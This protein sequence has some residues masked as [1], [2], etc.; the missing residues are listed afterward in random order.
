MPVF[1]LLLLAA[2][3]GPDTLWDWRTPSNPRISPDGSKVVYQL[4]WADKMADTFHVNLWIASSDGKDNRPLTEG[5]H[6]DTAHVWSPD[7][8]SLAYISTRSGRP[9]VAVRYV[10]T[11]V[12]TTITNLDAAMSDLS[13]SLDSKWIAFFSRIKAKAAWSIKSTPPPS[14]AKWIE[15]PSVVSNLQWRAD[16]IGGQ[17]LLPESLHHLFVISADGVAPRQVTSGDFTH[18]G[19]AAWT[20]DGKAIILSAARYPAGA[21]LYPYDLHRVQ[22]DTGEMRPLLTR[23]GPESDAVVSPDGKWVAF[24][25]FED[26]AKS[27]HSSRL[28]V[29]GIDGQG[30]KMLAPSLDRN[31]HS[32]VWKADSTGLY[33][34]IESS[35]QSHLHI[36]SLSGSIEPLTSGNLRFSTAYGSS[37]AFRWSR[38]AQSRSLP[39]LRRIPRM[40]MHCAHRV[41]RSGLPTSIRTC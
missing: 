35:G 28:W 38:T 18:N 25:G 6:R 9:Q 29:V 26:K 40:S 2:T 19:P 30:L 24:L 17:G 15:G 13:W 20:P 39:P 33:T 14:G 16:V 7:G 5:K 22:V 32:P 37:D 8:K 34:V 4:E 31:Y 3:L 10:D 41:L 21:V 11:G 12:E 1:S 23:T 36:A 27:S